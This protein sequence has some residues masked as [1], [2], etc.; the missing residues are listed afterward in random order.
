[1]I[2]RV[3]LQPRDRTES[4]N[5]FI[6]II[7]IIFFLSLRVLTM[8][9]KQILILRSR[10]EKLLVLLEKKVFF[11]FQLTPFY[12]ICDYLSSF[13]LWK[14][15]NYETFDGTYGSCKVFLFLFLFLYILI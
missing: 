4:T 6:I 9:S 14:I 11:L 15:Y 8:W 10:K 12:E 3:I 13:R 1:M 5:F 7:I 2:L